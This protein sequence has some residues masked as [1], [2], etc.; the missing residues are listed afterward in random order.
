MERHELCKAMSP[1]M[2]KSF[3]KAEQEALQEVRAES[4]RYWKER[5]TIER[6]WDK[7]NI[8]EWTLIRDTYHLKNRLIDEQIKVLR[9][10][11]SQA[12]ED[13]RKQEDEM[14]TKRYN[15]VEP[16]LESSKEAREANSKKWREIEAQVVD[17]YSARLQ[18]K[19][20]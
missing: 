19:G 7:Q 15:A 16:L 14:Y 10:A 12:F 17:K 18:K 2:Y 3:A 6:E 20:A 5:E 9:E 4:N 8:A 11:Q 1:Q 13:M